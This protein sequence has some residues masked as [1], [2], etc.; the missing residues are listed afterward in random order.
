MK[1]METHRKSTNEPKHLL[2][3]F[4]ENLARMPEKPLYV[5]IGRDGEA[6]DSVSFG[7]MSR[8]IASYSRFL[9]GRVG[10]GEKVALLYSSAHDFIPAFLGCLYKGAL[11]IAFQVPNSNFKFEKM[12]RVLR[13]GDVKHI[14]VSRSVMDKTWFR[15]SMS[16]HEWVSDF[17]WII[18][19]C[20][21]NPLD[22]T[23]FSPVAGMDEPMYFQLSSGSTGDQRLVPVTASNVFHN[24]GSVG[25]RIGSRREDV[26]LSWL[27][28]YHD[29][30]LVGALFFP[31][32]YGNTA[33][34]IDPLDFVSNPKVWVESVARHRISLSFMPNFALDL[35]TNRVDVGKLAPGSSLTPLRGVFVGAEPIRQ[36]TLKA[37]YDKFSV[38]GFS[39]ERFLVGYGMAESTLIISVKD[40]HSPLRTCRPFPEGREYVTCGPP[41]EGLEVRIVR[42]DG[43]DGPVGEVVVEGPIV[44]PMFQDGVLH[45]GDLGF[46]EGGELFITG[47]K[48]ELLIVNGV[49]HMLHEMEELVEG[50][51]FVQPQGALA[52]IDESDRGEDF[53]MLIE[54]RRQHLDAGD[55]EGFARAVN[56]IFN[57]EMGISPR[58]TFFLP[59]ASIPRTSSGKKYRVGWQ[60]LLSESAIG[61]KHVHHA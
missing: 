54:L 7:G 39:A 61:T 14:L 42:G 8:R 33:Y 32:V 6:V 21:D 20:A 4:R 41:I 43:D 57:R 19:E 45:T 50:L 1:T 26:Y 16:A 17:N 15:K 2:S 24:V 52:C 23:P 59:P 11:P 44:S 56:A 36:S 34:L 38:L 25:E 22:Y 13:E 12:R 55:K 53:V 37:F 51:D 58:E 40:A 60:K 3:V 9:D 46:M 10:E 49:K 48:R 5:R 47:R 29:L 28:H 31:L 18:D 30:G 27:P 35:C